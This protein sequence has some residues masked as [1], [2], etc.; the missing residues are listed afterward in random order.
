MTGKRKAPVYTLTEL[1]VLIGNYLPA[2]TTVHIEKTGDVCRELARH[3][4]D[5][6]C[7]WCDAR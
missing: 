7:R 6:R 5:E 4:N 1:D 3:P 2:T